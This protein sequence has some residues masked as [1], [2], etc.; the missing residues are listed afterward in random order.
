MPVAL[1]TGA[2]RGIGK[3][4]AVDLAAAGF[5]VT[6]TARTLVDGEGRADTD[7]DVAVPGGLDTTLALVEVTA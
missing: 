7:P 6:V 5:D 1:V 4:A 3:A 2:S